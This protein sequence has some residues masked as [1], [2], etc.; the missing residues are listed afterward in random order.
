[1]GMIFSGMVFSV[2]ASSGFR[3][4]RSRG[5]L[6]GGSK[7]SAK[8]LVAIVLLLTAVTAGRADD[9]DATQSLVSLHT[10]PCATCQR[11]EDEVWL[12]NDR[13]SDCIEEGADPIASLQFRRF[14]VAADQWQDATAADFF[15]GPGA[16]R[17]ACYWVHGDR[18]DSSEAVYA[19]LT[20]YRRL[21]EG[22]CDAP[23]LRFVIW[24]W[25]STQVYRR[26]VPDVRLKASRTPAE[27]FRLGYVLSR[28][29]GD[30]PVGLIGYSFGSRVVT[31]A[32]HVLGGGELA[33]HRLE[34]PA[35]TAKY[36]AALLASATDYDWLEPGEPHGMALKSA[37]GLLLINNGCDRVLAHYRVLACDRHGV[38]ALGYCGV[39]SLSALGPD[40]EKVRQHDACCDVGN[41]HWWR[42]YI[43]SDSVMGQVRA[44][45]LPK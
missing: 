14:D 38:P 45:V 27:G 42:L 40:G 39:R 23:P 36:R 24:S 18:I 33:G 4:Y 7:W 9:E 11:N 13:H 6:T 8:S 17:P 19:G 41:R 34:K 31:G 12:I 21:V 15:G 5:S 37:A 16:K 29:P 3:P 10:A 26:P 28:T 22:K 35:P 1:M 20:V 32:L 25:P 30:A 44:T 2:R 43:C